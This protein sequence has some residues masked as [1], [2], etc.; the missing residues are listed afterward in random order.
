MKDKIDNF[1]SE[2]LGLIDT[3]YVKLEDQYCN[4]YDFPDFDPLRDEICKCLIFDLNQA[5]ITLTN[6]LL[7]CFLKVSIIY[8]DTI[9]FNKKSN[10][11]VENCFKESIDKY[12]KLELEQ[13][14]NIACSQE[15]ISKE[16]KKVFK[17]FKD[18]F[19]NPYSHAQKKTIFNNDKIS[20]NLLKLGNG[21]IE[22][23]DEKQFK[24]ID[25]LF[26]QGF[27][28]AVK[29]KNDAYDYFTYVDS[30]IRETLSKLITRRHTS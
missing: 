27:F 3:N 1:K 7:E 4:Q 25:L 21:N 13:S 6:H 18:H 12:D 10:I 22:I 29:A 11:E 5:A 23:S 28:Q 16:Q 20:G 2:I 30:V 17:D 8:K 19:R 15:L 9:A 26:T 14:I 24:V